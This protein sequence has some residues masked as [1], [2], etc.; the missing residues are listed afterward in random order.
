VARLRSGP[1]LGRFYVE[2]NVRGSG[3]ECPLHIVG[4]ESTEVKIP[5]LSRSAREGWGTRLLIAHARS[6]A[7]ATSQ[8]S[9][10]RGAQRPAI[11]G[12]DNGN[13]EVPPHREPETRSELPESESPPKQGLDGALMSNYGPLLVRGDREKD[14][15]VAVGR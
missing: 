3:R 6:K 8:S 15:A 12:G 14:I 13:H 5:T 4:S 7:Q 10:P 2:I 9:C 1:S 11:S